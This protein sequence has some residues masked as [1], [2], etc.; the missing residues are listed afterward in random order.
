MTEPIAVATRQCRCRLINAKAGVLVNYLK[1]WTPNTTTIKNPT[2]STSQPVVTAL[3]QRFPDI[4]GTL[5]KERNPIDAATLDY[6]ERLRVEGLIH[7]THYNTIDNYFG[8]FITQRDYPHP[9]PW[10][11][12]L[13]QLQQLYSMCA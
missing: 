7:G 1:K 10:W 8:V 11:D 13:L 3:M 2:K 5:S 6:L 4:T 9:I 12:A